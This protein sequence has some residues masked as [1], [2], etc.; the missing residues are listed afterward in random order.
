MLWRRSALLLMVLLF[1]AKTAEL[2]ALN[3]KVEELIR[4]S[5]EKDVEA[6][7]ELSTKLKLVVGQFDKLSTTV[8][9]RV[10]IA[11]NNVSFQKR[12]KQVP[13][14]TPRCTTSNGLYY[15]YTVSQKSSH[16]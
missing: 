1:Q 9:N 5:V 10:K 12:V 15:Y 11:V 14:T 2:N 6:G 13:I 3:M 4:S 16:L 8:N 7:K